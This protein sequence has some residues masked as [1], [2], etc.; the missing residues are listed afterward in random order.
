MA[1]L[2]AILFK[3][4]KQIPAFN[5]DFLTPFF[6][7]I[8]NLLGFGYKQRVK[9]VNLL[10]LKIGER[11]LDLGCGTGSLLIVAKSKFPNVDMI[12][13][14]VD[15]KVLEIAEKKIKKENLN[16]KL[17]KSSADK[18]PFPDNSFDVIVSTL[19]FHHLPTEVK[20]GALK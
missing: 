11:L 18:L 7:S 13:V 1:K 3:M 8:S 6:D 10:D 16:I 14:D 17:I 15:S 4:D 12:G 5:Y 20:K 9:I 2:Y 19:V